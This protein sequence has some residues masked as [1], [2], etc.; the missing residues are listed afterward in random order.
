[1]FDFKTNVFFKT[2]Q[3]VTALTLIPLLCAC[4]PDSQQKEGS[5]SAVQISGAMRNVM[6]KGELQGTIALDTISDKTHLYGL[7]PIEYLRGELLIVD[8]EVWQSR[9]VSDSTMKLE[10]DDQVKAPFFVYANVAEWKEIPCQTAS[11]PSNNW[12]A[13]WMRLRRMLHVLLYLKLRVR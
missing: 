6:M 8:G 2:Q 4:K 7:G 9:V 5:S 10:K 1:M 11:D 13:G 12:K 3:F